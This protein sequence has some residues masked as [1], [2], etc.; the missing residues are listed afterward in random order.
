VILL[1]VIHQ[2]GVSFK[3]GAALWTLVALAVLPVHGETVRTQV[4]TPREPALAHL[5]LELPLTVVDS[6]H[7]DVQVALEGELFRGNTLGAHQGGVSDVFWMSSSYVPTQSSEGAQF[8]PTVWALGGHAAGAGATS[9]RDL[10]PLRCF[11][12]LYRT[13]TRTR[14]DSP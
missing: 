13:T 11:V 4:R 8:A 6:P 9:R 1:Q 14:R 10:L 12:E 3:L 7:M 2:V 5:A